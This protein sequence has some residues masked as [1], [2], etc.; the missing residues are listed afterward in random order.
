MD[1]TLSHLLYSENDT[2]HSSIPL[3]KSFCCRFVAYTEK[4]NTFSL[5]HITC[6]LQVTMNFHND[7][8][9]DHL[10][11]YMKDGNRKHWQQSFTFLQRSWTPKHWDA[12]SMQWN[13]FQFHPLSLIFSPSLSCPTINKPCSNRVRRRSTLNKMGWL[14]TLALQVGAWRL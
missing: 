9:T 2:T 4:K 10:W 6:W 1:Y 3:F 5:F 11:N 7:K 14:W 13:N 12:F 8:W